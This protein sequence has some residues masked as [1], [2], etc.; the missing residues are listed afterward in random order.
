MHQYKS[1]AS[2]IILVMLT[3]CSENSSP[4]QTPP[5]AVQNESP[6]AV[7][8]SISPAE[9]RTTI[10]IEGSTSTDSDGTI[11]TYMWEL[12]NNSESEISII[13]PDQPTTEIEIGE[14]ASN[15]NLEVTLTVTD[16]EGATGT[17]STSFTVEEIDVEQLPPNPGES[18]L[19]T[20][21]GVD[22]NNNE[23][24][25][26]IEV[27]ILEL[28]PLDR[29]MR[30]VQSYG[31][32][33]FQEALVAAQANSDVDAD[34]AMQKISDWVGCMRILQESGNMTTRELDI[35]MAM[36]NSLVTNTQTRVE[37]KLEFNNMRGGT[38]YRLSTPTL[39][40]CEL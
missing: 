20:L 9:E 38:A 21:E 17:T 31:A 30:L 3:A 28:Y 12:N 35:E 5:P 16:N 29:D 40:D 24:R 11:S 32:V 22:S 25:D 13:T 34:T 26:D 10:S 15:L 19:V 1:L 6:T 36:L 39:Q 8:S 18:G 27:R 4:V 23:I 33:A 14:V 7:I 37:N 2:S